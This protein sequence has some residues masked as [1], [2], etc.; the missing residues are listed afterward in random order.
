MA[1][2]NNA[3]LLFIFLEISEDL[4]FNLEETRAGGDLQRLHL[5]RTL[6]IQPKI[7]TTESQNSLECKALES[8][9]P[10]SGAPSLT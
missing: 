5:C 2:V 4:V 8:G 7:F 1:V 3:T 10:R 9:I 6:A